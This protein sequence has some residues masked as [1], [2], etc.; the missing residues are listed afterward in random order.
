VAPLAGHA[1]PATGVLSYTRCALQDPAHRAALG[2]KRA[3]RVANARRAP[4]VRAVPVMERR[5]VHAARATNA[6]PAQN[7]CPEVA[8]C[9]VGWDR[10]AAP[11][12]PPAR[13][14]AL[15]RTEPA[16]VK[17]ADY[18]VP[19]TSARQRAPCARAPLAGGGPA[20]CVGCRAS[21][22]V[23]PGLLARSRTASVRLAPVGRAA[24]LAIHAAAETPA[25]E[26]IRALEGLA[27]RSRAHIAP[28]DFGIIPLTMLVFITSIGASGSA[29]RQPLVDG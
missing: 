22:A 17:S 28:W 2:G 18:A 1:A 10:S 29:S 15:V 26:P 7:A 16:V 14:G 9:A 8:R 5:T 6:Q 24:T 13:A 20:R 11:L 23:P 25:S 3:V 21:H 4:L 27:G 19:A 12:A